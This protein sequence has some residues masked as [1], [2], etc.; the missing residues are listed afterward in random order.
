MYVDIPFG[1]MVF[2]LC[3]SNGHIIFKGM[4]RMRWFLFISQNSGN[5]NTAET[6][7]NRH[8]CC[9]TNKNVS[10][11]VHVYDRMCVCVSMDVDACTCV[12]VC[13]VYLRN[14]PLD[15]WVKGDTVVKKS[16]G[17]THTHRRTCTH[18]YNHI[19][20]MKSPRRATTFLISSSSSSLYMLD[21]ISF[22]T[23]WKALSVERMML[24]WLHVV[25]S[26]SVIAYIVLVFGFRVK[27]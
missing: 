12:S 7:N 17:N 14:T 20:S 13:A 24:H 4:N 9:S 21:I 18:Q 6:G 2:I 25:R 10:T 19:Q 3:R 26:F 15:D 27:V 1:F 11:R 16:H 23:I 5:N 22:E 8:R